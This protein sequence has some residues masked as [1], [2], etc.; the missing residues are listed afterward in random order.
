MTERD[1]IRRRRAA[2]RKRHWVRLTRTCNSRC[3]FC[4]DAEFQ[5]GEMRDD[6]AVRR[7]IQE[8]LNQGAEAVI[9]SGGEPTVHPE[10]LSLVAFAAGQGYRWIQV[11]TNGRMFAYPEFARTDG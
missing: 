1:P 7:D 10:F 3:R 11:V 8:G 2:F 4:L 9:L 5:N 6:G